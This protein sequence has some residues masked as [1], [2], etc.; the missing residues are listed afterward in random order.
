V[1]AEEIL[2]YHGHR[3]WALPRRPWIMRQQW[4]RLLFA[5]WALP[6]EA[7][8]PLV[9]PELTLDIFEGRC[10]VA[11]TPFHLSRLR[12]PGLSFGGLSFPELN[13]RT[14]V[15]LDGKPGVYFFSLDAGSVMA[16][17][18]ARTI[19]GLPYFYA[20]MKIEYDGDAVRYQCR[21]SH[22]GNVAEF[23]AHYRP[24]SPPRA[25][26][27]GTLEHF[28]TERYCLY[29]VEAGRIYRAHIHH[30]PWPLQP[31]EAEISRNTMAAAARIRLPDSRP[32]LHFARALEV[33]VW[34][35]ERLK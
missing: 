22:L 7:L 2:L 24:V 31:A 27:P 11:V 1:T 3:P 13:V 33:L 35:P 28:L 29:A 30:L 19:Y 26:M 25:S 23:Q 10:W 15:T 5:H 14:Y 4:N 12:P 21:R 8:R 32:L 20:R 16:V 34:A 18:G 9:P 17:F 6:P